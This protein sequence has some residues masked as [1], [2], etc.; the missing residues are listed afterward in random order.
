MKG[1]GWVGEAFCNSFHK[2]ALGLKSK[3][4]EKLKEKKIPSISPMNSM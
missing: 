1:G 4:D 3:P 2:M